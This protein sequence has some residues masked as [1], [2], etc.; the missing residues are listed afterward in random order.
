L[1]FSARHAKE[2]DYR[3]AQ[4]RAAQHR[5]PFAADGYPSHRRR[6][7]R[8]ESRLWAG[9]C[10]WHGERGLLSSVQSH[11]AP[12]AARVVSGPA[13][14]AELSGRC[15][16]RG[17]LRAYTGTS[18]AGSWN[19][20]R[21]LFR[22]VQPGALIRLTVPDLEKYVQF[23]LHGSDGM[24]PPPPVRREVWLRCPSDP[25]IDA[26]FRSCLGLGL[27][28]AGVRTGAKRLHVRAAGHVS[29]L[30]RCSLAP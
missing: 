4:F 29:G 19:L 11:R 3:A 22:I 16:Q 10:S 15:V 17:L 26:G 8:A 2:C 14:S 28:G 5:L 25:C 6:S 13:V 9:L 1:R 18:D 23:Y 7:T 20:L 24:T 12:C 30:R 27:R 21:E